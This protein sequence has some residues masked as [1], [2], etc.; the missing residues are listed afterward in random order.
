[1]TMIP[2]CIFMSTKNLIENQDNLNVRLRAQ[3]FPTM[4]K[5]PIN[6]FNR[7]LSLLMGI[8]ILISFASCTNN[9][10]ELKGGSNLG[11]QPI[12]DSVYV[13][14][15][16]S[17]TPG[18][19][20]HMSWAK[21][22]YSERGFKLGWFKNNQIVPQAGQMLDIIKKSGEEGLNPKD[23]QIKNIDQL[24]SDLKA[25]VKD[26]AKFFALEK[27]IDVALS[28][29]YFAWASDYYRGTVVPKENKEIEWDVKSNK[30][31]LHK[32]LM[33]V[34]GER[35]SKYPYADFQPLHPEYIRLKAALANYRKIQAAG[36]WPSIP[37]GA[38][39]KPGD[40]SATVKILYKRLIG[41]S[42]DTAAHA[43]YD[44]NLVSA[45]KQFQTQN[46]LKADGALGSETIKLLNIPIDQRIKQIIL[47][48]ERWRWI[49][50][51]FEPDYLL[52]NIPEY[53]LHVFE[54]G[55]EKITMKV[56]VG[57]TLNS[58]PVFS[59][60]ME[61]VVLSPYWNVPMS[62]LQ[63][64]IAP[65]L[66]SNPNYLEHL[67]MEIITS[68]GTP[69][70]P[71]SIDWSSVNESNFKYTV[72]RRPGPEND[73]GDVKFVF[74]NSMDIYL[75]DTPHHELFGQA[76]R[77]FSH[78][79]VRVEKPIELAEYLL[80]NKPGYDK[81]TILNIV[82][83]RKEK[84]VALKQKLPVYLV[85]FTAWADESGQVH[86]RDDIYGHDKKLAREYFN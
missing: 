80:R 17:S 14:K 13:V 44:E 23:Y 7:S 1:V 65:K 5:K 32:A 25:S 84:H 31:K 81:S 24:F 42:V 85:Y 18:F 4:I 10:K 51:K 73:L 16:L 72:R 22:F 47:N 15:Y 54:K 8:S 83:Q 45:V 60:R 59:D 58:T 74:P 43:I 78:G 75:H 49:P 19:K 34:L 70:S 37:A 76:K 27:E 64:E 53:K 86:F 55:A 33:T 11:P 6:F 50:K 9:T 28:A 67:D 40:N 56:I 68:Q 38:K 26:S 29:T 20:E 46:G 12:L 39:I 69:V 66:V 3:H 82:S 21:K 52:V 62:I 48:M 2:K 35:E 57:K 79:C 61:S 30:I 77:G 36:G 41:S 63:K 71:S